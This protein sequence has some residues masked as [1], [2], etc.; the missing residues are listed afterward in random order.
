MDDT[1]NVSNTLQS[2]QDSNVKI[3]SNFAV[4]EVAR[5]VVKNVINKV[6]IKEILY[7]IG[8]IVVLEQYVLSL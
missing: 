1:R 2:L 5:T 7:Y 8:D 6:W 4:H 3:K